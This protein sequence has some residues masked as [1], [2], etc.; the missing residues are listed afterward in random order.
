MS[1][2]GVFKAFQFN[3]PDGVIKESKYD[4][5]LRM[6]D[7]SKTIIKKDGT[8][9]EISFY[10]GMLLNGLRG[11]SIEIL[12]PLD[13][14]NGQYEFETQLFNRDDEMIVRHFGSFIVKEEDKVDRGFPLFSGK[15]EVS[16]T[17]REERLSICN[18]CPFKVEGICQKCGCVVENKV[19]L[20]SDQC[21]IQKW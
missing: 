15:K 9:K 3:L 18:I 6:D 7:L 14:E 11:W 1:D 21:P 13:C 19:R 8:I 5:D 4:I 20:E 16:K 10:D 12:L 2:S 17:I